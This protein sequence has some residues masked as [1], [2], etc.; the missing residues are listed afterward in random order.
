VT[1]PTK[2]EILPVG[3]V[4]VTGTATDNTAVQRV[5]V[6]VKDRAAGLWWDGA[7][8]GSFTWFDA[9]LAS[10]G[11]A[12][13]DWSWTFDAGPGLYGFL[14]AAEDSSGNADP[15]KPWVPITVE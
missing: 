1:A 14:V 15:T 4:D 11:A 9:T 6:A 8:W 3:I 7:A 12:T 13:T 5:R 2:Q 10:P